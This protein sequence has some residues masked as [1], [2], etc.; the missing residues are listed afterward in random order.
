MTG[1]AYPILQ[2]LSLLND[3]ERQITACRLSSRDYLSSGFPMI[4]IVSKC[5]LG[6]RA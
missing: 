2:R 5:G 1:I 6:L 4:R 3:S